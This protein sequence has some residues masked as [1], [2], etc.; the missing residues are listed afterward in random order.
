MHFWFLGIHEI[1]N[2]TVILGELVLYFQVY[3][4]AKKLIS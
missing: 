1:N 2:K 3:D 4:N